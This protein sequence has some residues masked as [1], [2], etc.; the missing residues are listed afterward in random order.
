MPISF[1]RNLFQVF[2]CRPL[3][4]WPCGVH[5]VYLFCFSIL[6]SFFACVQASSTFFFLAELVRTPD[7]FVSIASHYHHIIYN[8]SLLLY[9]FRLSL[10]HISL[11]KS[12]PKLQSFIYQLQVR[13]TVRLTSNGFLTG[14][15]LGLPGSS[16]QSS[17]L[18]FLLIFRYISQQLYSLLAIGYTSVFEHVKVS[19]KYLFQCVEEVA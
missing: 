2:F 11:K 7:Q 12:F 13:V 19:E 5:V 14:H 3:F 9:S 6:S 8:I 18:F 4:L 10:K 16:I 17:S 15:F 1:F